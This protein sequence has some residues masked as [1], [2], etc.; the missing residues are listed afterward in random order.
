M[1]ELIANKEAM[2]LVR[3]KL[4]ATLCPY[5]SRA[6]FE[7]AIIPEAVPLAHVLG[8]AGEV[9]QL[10]RR[11]DGDWISGDGASWHARQLAT[12]EE[13]TACLASAMAA[14]AEAQ[15]AAATASAAAATA[16]TA[17]TLLVVVSSLAAIP[18]PP[19]ANTLYVVIPA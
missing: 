17:A 15:A 7:A 2:A 12:I 13:M 10:S 16:V 5:T 19:A 9:W 4:N 3:A 18:V 11:V 1:S 8:A 14:V 6:E